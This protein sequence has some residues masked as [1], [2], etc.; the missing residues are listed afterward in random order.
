MNTK[1]LQ[2][3]LLLSFIGAIASITA[4]AQGGWRQWDLHLRDGST[5]QA[6]PLGLRDSRF[7]RS[8]SKDERGIDRAKISYISAVAN[9]LPPI[10]TADVK[11]DLV[12]QMDGKRTQG[13]VTF[14][15]IRFSEGTIVQNGKEMTLEN[16]AY[17]VFAKPRKKVGS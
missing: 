2:T 1:C 5:V 7:T 4:A 13:T 11:K 17:I 9:S 3:I 8:M 12:V 6:N 15:E 14:K 10:P 16:V